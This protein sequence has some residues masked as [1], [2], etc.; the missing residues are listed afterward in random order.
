[1]KAATQ[2]VEIA[3]EQLSVIRLSK[4]RDFPKPDLGPNIDPFSMY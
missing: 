4:H 3:K 1:M 2:G